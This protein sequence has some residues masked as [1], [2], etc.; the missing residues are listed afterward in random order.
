MRHLKEAGKIK[1]GRMLTL[2]LACA[3][4]LNTEVQGNCAKTQFDGVYAGANVG[5]MN[6]NTSLD[7]KQDPGNVRADAYNSTASRGF[8]MIEALLGFGKV[9]LGSFY[10]GVEGRVDWVLGG[11]QKSAEDISFKYISGRKGP[12]ITFLARLGY[13]V[14]PTTMIYGGVGVKAVQFMYDLF[15]KADQ[16]SAPFSKRSLNLLTEVGIETSLSPF[17]NIRFRFSYAFTATRSMTRKSTDF[18]SNHMYGSQGVFKA[19]TSEHALKVGLI[20]RF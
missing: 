12:G 11:P 4:I 20:Y 13:L 19:G 6:Q 18:P 3:F 14:T 8:P 16:I 15:E 10:G 17:Q 9:F 7:A 2:P 1:R 5:Y